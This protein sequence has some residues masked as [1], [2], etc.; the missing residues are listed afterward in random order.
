[1]NFIAQ[2]SRT[3]LFA[4]AAATAFDA[5]AQATPAASTPGAS[6]ATSTA[7]TAPPPAAGASAQKLERIQVTG[8]N[9][10]A[11]RRQSTASR[12]VI[13]RDDLLKQGDTSVAEALK[14]VPGVTIGGAPGRGGAIRMRGL[15]GGFTRILLNGE[16]LPRGFDLDSLSPEVVERI[17]VFRSATAEFSSQA[18]AGAI[19]IVTRG[20]VSREVREL[21]LGGSYENGR[22]S[23][24]LG[25]RFSGPQVADS[26]LLGSV[27]YALNGQLSG[28]RF[29]RENRRTER[30]TDGAGAVL[31]DR[32]GALKNRENQDQLNVSN[33]FQWNLGRGE[34]LA[35]EPF[36][37]AQQ[38]T[39]RSR[40][41]ST[42]SVGVPSAFAKSDSF[43]DF[44]FASSR[45][46]LSWVKPLGTNGG[47]I[48]ASGGF[49]VNRFNGQFNTDG[50]D[51]S[52]ALLLRR[53]QTNVTSSNGIST[54][55]KVTVPTNEK[56][57]LALGWDI[58]AQRS[59]ETRS[60]REQSFSANVQAESLEEDYSYRSQQLAFYVQDE[61]K[62][63]DTFSLYSGARWEG[64]EINTSTTGNPQ[65]NPSYRNKS[66]V[67][68]PSLQALYKLG[69]GN[70]NQL[71]AAISRTYR[72]PNP[73]QLSPRRF[74]SVNNSATSPDSQGNP[75]L[76]PELAWGLD[77]G[78][79]HYLASGG[80]LTANLFY[81]AIDDVFR[82]DTQFVNGRWL[83]QPINLGKASTVGLE[84]EAKFGLQSIDKDLPKIELRSNLAVYTSKVDAI[85]GPNNRLEQ[86]A[87]AVLN[88]GADWTVAGMPLTVGGNLNISTGGEVRTAADQISYTNVK[89]SLDLYANYRFNAK[90]SLRVSVANGL[91]QDQIFGTTFFLPEGVTS[92]QTTLTP[93][94]PIL[95]AQYTHRF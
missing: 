78:Y 25:F 36:L 28:N 60:R 41:T 14:R 47:R 11:Q 48:E 66:S 30:T 68:S 17:E 84:L 81:R 64:I 50:L 87:P 57:D 89:R 53:A 9:D 29:L 4:F 72:A 44:G 46:N 95:R 82:S 23:P 33:R 2:L 16:P 38:T 22:T 45:M 83:R 26:G 75:G 67:L 77:V 27:S 59:E 20:P 56:H 73:F 19:N 13:S 70:R 15:G 76:K 93:T 39:I 3:A 65:L 91:A 18:V 86:Q 31:Q 69:E 10:D 42:T 34:S 5:S 79:E 61:W 55:G 54:R 88:L 92:L 24:Q 52:N 35:L 51:A 21:T 43:N 90:Q 12:I 74:L 32:V 85:P 40:E 49:N 94:K 1:M 80:V 6:S 71:R 8:A 63:S 7:A 58:S 37:F 62:A